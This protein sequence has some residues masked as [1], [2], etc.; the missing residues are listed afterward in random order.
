MRTDELPF[1]SEQK[2]MAVKCRNH[3]TAEVSRLK[4]RSRYTVAG[5]RVGVGGSV[6][7][8]G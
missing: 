6:S 2:W 3:S 4:E 1:N 7:V 8:G 5:I